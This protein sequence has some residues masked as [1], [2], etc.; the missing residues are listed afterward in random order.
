MLDDIKKTAQNV[1]TS[2]Y[3]ILALLLIP[4]VIAA[5]QAEML[6]TVGLLVIAVPIYVLK[7]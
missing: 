3:G 6:V 7:D 2:K 4:A 1:L 5:L